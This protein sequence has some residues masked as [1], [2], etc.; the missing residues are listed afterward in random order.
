[1]NE[2]VEKG[3]L[4][5][6]FLKACTPGQ[7]NFEGDAKGERYSVLNELYGG[8]AIAYFQI[9][10]ERSLDYPYVGK[11]AEVWLWTHPPIADRMIFVQRYNPWAEG[12]TP[13]FVK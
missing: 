8:G 5:Q 9:L 4:R 13:E 2:V 1:M 11:L 7:Y 6:Q 3:A 12:Q 10:G